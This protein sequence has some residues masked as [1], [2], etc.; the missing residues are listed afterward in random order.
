VPN[1][2]HPDVASAPQP[3]ELNDSVPTEHFVDVDGVRIR[4]LRAGSG[5]PLLLVHGL[6]GYSFSWRHN[7]AA[8]ARRAT[9]YAPDLPGAGYSARAKIDGSLRGLAHLLLRFMD[10]VGIDSADVVGTSHGGA[11]VMTLAAL[12]AA[13]CLE[14]GACIPG[15]KVS[16]QTGPAVFKPAVPSSRQARVR[17]LILVAPVNP[18]SFGRQW[19]VRV[20]GTRPGA[21]AALAL[22]PAIR[23]S[24]GYFL[25]RLYVNPSRI[26]PG[27]VEGYVAP[28]TIPGSITHVLRTLKPW[29]TD[30]RALDAALPRI[31][32]IPTLL[33][34]GSHDTVIHPA[35]AS[36]LA[37][38][39]HNCDIVTLQG[40]GHLP[41][42]ELPDQFNA[43]VIRFLRTE[44]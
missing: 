4:Y 40:A 9:V 22:A 14:A 23:A 25:R 33:I 30:V 27:T 5:P 8:L 13:A 26:T 42:E 31:A 21:I 28:L 43:A 37:Q 38:R 29:Q 39:F 20:L 12:D 1:L 24:R 19:L 17:R 16:S 7:I 32:H 6:L 10:A 34:W 15:P 36:T 41:Y 44:N 3:P 2:T 18:W 35:S 11:V